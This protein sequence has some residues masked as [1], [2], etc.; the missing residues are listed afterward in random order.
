MNLKSLVILLG[1]TAFFTFA[2]GG[3]TIK[4]TSTQGNSVDVDT[5]KVDASKDTNLSENINLSSPKKGDY[6]VTTNSDSSANKS[7]KKSNG[8]TSVKIKTSTSGDNSAT[9]SGSK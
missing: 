9:V 6:S 4:I 3:S 7:T 8:D 1:L 5:P 2:Y